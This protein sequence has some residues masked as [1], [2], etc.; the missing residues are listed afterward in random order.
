MKKLK[1]VGFVFCG[2]YIY[3]ALSLANAQNVPGMDRAASQPPE[4][5]IEKIFSQLNLTDAQ[6]HQLDEN[7]NG[8]RAEMQN[9]RQEMKAAKEAMREELMK[10]QLD[11]AQVNAIQNRIKSLSSQMEDDRL[12]S[13]LAVRSILTPDQ[14]LKF[15]NLM[16]KHRPEHDQ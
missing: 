8:H 2:I 1:R 13:I 16:H 9:A 5:H 4:K 7:K 3:A 10:P 11:M 15:A 14:F 12:N 6:K